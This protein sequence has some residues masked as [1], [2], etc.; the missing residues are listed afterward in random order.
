M[1]SGSIRP[2]QI[3]PGSLWRLKR[4]ACECASQSWAIFTGDPWELDRNASWEQIATRARWRCDIGSCW[5]LINIISLS[6]SPVRDY[7]FV[8]PN[9]QLTLVRFDA[10]NMESCLELVE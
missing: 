6:P 4:P 2:N 3:V 7:Q 5:L 10:T 1:S 9:E 8:L